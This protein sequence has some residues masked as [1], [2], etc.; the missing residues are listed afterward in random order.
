MSGQNKFSVAARLNRL[1]A[2]HEA[3]VAE[4]KALR[5]YFDAQLK[6]AV[7]D[8]VGATGAPGR[9]GASIVG[10]QGIPGRDGA[11][12]TIPGPAGRAGTAI[13][14]D[15]GRTGATPQI[16]IGE[17]QT[18]E[19]DQPVRVWLTGTDENPVINFAIPRGASIKGD[20]GD[21]IVG[22]R[23][24]CTIPNDGELRAAVLEL[25]KKHVAVLAK[26]AYEMELNGQRKHG[27]LRSTIDAV[28]KVIEIEA[29]K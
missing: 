2:Q 1:E 24:D 19:A 25:R 27:G 3:L 6:N 15:R 12:S 4:N 14:G 9:D 10:P 11:A 5:T 28:L 18:I 16:S 13:K 17:V 21:S 29:Q 8:S 22:P 23:G 7:N 20:K 26:L